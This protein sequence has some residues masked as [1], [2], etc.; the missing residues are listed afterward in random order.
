[1]ERGKR[2]AA[3]TVVNDDLRRAQADLAA[4]VA[5]TRTAA[6]RAATPEDT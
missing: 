2:V 5:G 4:I 6:S 3:F 1:V